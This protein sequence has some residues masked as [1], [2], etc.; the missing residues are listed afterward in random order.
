[1]TQGANA[2]AQEERVAFSVAFAVDLACM[3][4]LESTA[5]PFP[6]DFRA[7]R[8]GFRV[9]SAQRACKVETWTKILTMCLFPPFLN[10]IFLAE[11]QEHFRFKHRRHLSLCRWCCNCCNNKGCGS[12]CKF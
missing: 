5:V 3:C 11:I 7:V 4:I 9:N 6:E 8:E 2:P 1:M 12:C 10:V